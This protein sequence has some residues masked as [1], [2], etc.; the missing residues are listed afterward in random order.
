MVCIRQLREIHCRAGTM[1][2]ETTHI[3]HRAWAAF[4]AALLLWGLFGATKHWPAL[5]PFAPFDTDPYD[6]VGSFTFQIAVAMGALSLVRLELIRRHGEMDRLVY[7]G[8]GIRVVAACIAI[9]M[10]S[11]LVAIVRAGVHPPRSGTE[12]GLWAV[13][14]GMTALS[15]LLVIGLPGGPAAPVPAPGGTEF[16]AVL[17]WLAPRALDP[18]RHP[19]RFALALALGLAAAVTA[20][21][22]VIGGPAPT[23]RQTILVVAVRMAIEGIGVFAGFLLLGPWLGL[24]GLRRGPASSAPS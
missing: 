2:L 13:I 21:E 18:H 15:A 5:A 22:I 1:T 9:T 3:G 11:D 20:A 14:A 12:A 17:R 8:R 10:V 7:V 24:I 23:L 4:I 16:D 19:V 6:V